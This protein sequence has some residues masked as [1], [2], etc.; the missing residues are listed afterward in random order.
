[1]PQRQRICSEIDAMMTCKLTKVVSK[2]RRT[3]EAADRPRGVVMIFN[4]K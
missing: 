1:M 2:S 4:E 3:Q